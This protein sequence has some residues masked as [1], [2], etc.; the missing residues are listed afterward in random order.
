[1]TWGLFHGMRPYVDLIDPN[2]PG[3]LLPHVLAYLLSGVHAWGLRV[4]DLFFLL[5]LLWATSWILAAWNTPRSLRLLAG[6]AY[7]LN[8]FGTGWCWT[9]QR[10]SFAWPIFVISTIPFLL[11]L[12]PT[13]VLN[14]AEGQ[15][16]ELR[17]SAWL[18]FGA[19]AG[20]SLWIKPVAWLA[21]V[22]LM[23][24]TPLVCE[25]KQRAKVM[26]QSCI[27]AG[28]V[29]VVSLLFIL[30][31]AATGT[32]GGFIKWGIQYDL[33]PYS[34]VKWPWPTRLWITGQFLL[35]PQFMP[36]P[37][38]L[39]VAGCVMAAALRL[40]RDRWRRHTRPL[41]AASALLLASLFTALLQGKLHSFYHFIPMNWAI[42][43]FAATIWSVIPWKK[44]FADVANMLALASV[45]AML[46]HGPATAGPTNGE[47]AADHFAPRLSPQEEVVVWGY[48]PSLLARLQRRTPFQTFIGT[49]FLITSPPDSWAAREV[50]DRLNKALHDPSVRYLFVDQ[51]ATLPMQP[52]TPPNPIDYLTRDPVLSA[53]LHREYRPL[54]HESLR[55]FDVFEHISPD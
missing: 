49:S 45:A 35:T 27:F 44:A 30:V 28:G 36:L 12:R 17:S 37:L 20:L 51:I 14:D 5:A 8:Y 3:I 48:A 25:P 52:T 19:L 41:L 2:W 13:A 15:R 34:Q 38:L 1:M 32:L 40:S 46:I 29:A 11:H 21:M 16:Q 4:V 43:F 18:V 9:A 33:G 31:L 54:E 53:T 24:M 42:A 39:L 7:L 55:G 23:A 50:M 6:C 47:L 10:E 22:L 26:R